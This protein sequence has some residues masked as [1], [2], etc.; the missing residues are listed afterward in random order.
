[1][2]NNKSIATDVAP[3]VVI[4]QIGGDLRLGGWDQNQ[5]TLMED[6]EITLQLDGDII[7]VRGLH[8]D[9]TLQVPMIASVTIREVHGDANLNTILGALQIQAIHGDARLHN[10]GNVVIQ[11]VGGD[12]TVRQVAEDLQ[13]ET[14]GGDIRL[15]EVLGNCRVNAGGD[16]HIDHVH[17]NLQA[18]GGGDAALR[19][20]LPPATATNINAGGDITCHLPAAANV[21]INATCGGEIRTK[22]LTTPMRRTEQ[23]ANLTLGTGEA[24]LQLH[25]GGDIRLLGPKEGTSEA[26]RAGRDVTGENFGAEFEFQAN[27]F[28]QQV[29][30]QVERQMTHLARHLDQRFAQFGNDE[31]LAS[32]VQEKV[33][34]AMRRAEEKMA[35]VMRRTEERM[36]AAEDR[37]AQQNEARRQQPQWRPG[38]PPPPPHA[39][40]P[41]PPQAPMAPQAPVAPVN[42]EERRTILRMVSE[43]KITVEQA[44]QLLTALLNPAAAQTKL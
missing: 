36:R 29:V 23:V 40:R 6:N 8:D 20:L 38:Q 39:T 13:V 28:A 27:D 11:Q 14:V 2:N 22:R 35:E 31:E 33:Q 4:D 3:K 42:D 9:C 21:Q 43:G 17:G 18:N 30:S 15:A 37:A 19:L 26:E 12:L 32:R 34:G 1:M 7:Y 16:L 41:M 24:A 44:D 25:G 5:V 10:V